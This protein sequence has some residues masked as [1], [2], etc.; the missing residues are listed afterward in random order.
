MTEHDIGIV[1]LGYVGLTLA[2][3]LADVGYSVIGVE[4]RSHLV[5]LTNRGLPH[6]SEAGLG[7]AL[8]RVTSAGKLVAAK[9]FGPD[10]TCGTYIIT[11]GTPLSET[12]DVRLDMIEAA[13]QQVAGNMPDD[14]LVILRS[15]V[16]VETTRKVVAPILARTGK[17]FHIAMCP[18]RTL[19]GRALQELRE[20][21]Q[22]IGADDPIA[23]DRAAAVFQRITSTIVKVSTPE[24]A[25]IVKLVDNT[26][27]DVQFAFANEVA[28]LCEAFRVNAHEV[29]SSGKL[30]YSRT[31]VA[32]PGLV[33][34]PC[35]E[36]DPHI[37]IQSAQAQGMTLEIT[38][39]ARLV[40]E[41]Q[42]IETVGFVKKEV[43]RRGLSH[44]LR[45]RVVGM[46]FKG[47]PA[48]DDLRGSMSVKVLAALKDA[49]PDAEFGVF[50]PV[51]KPE[52][53]QEAFPAEEVF[54]TL[55]EAIQ[56][57]SVLVIANNHP[58]LGTFSPRTI[59]EIIAD[60]GFVFDFW[61]HFSHLPTSELGDSYFAVGNT[62]TAG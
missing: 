52:L 30:G 1:G 2:T 19:E 41:R 8:R 11:V 43:A 9:E 50:D 49:H 13:T 28:R 40:N 10:I 31:N 3:V 45:I 44:P 39:A 58:D 38:S 17:R 5:D 54:S 18:E 59:G 29:I 61:N 16:K 62:E 42:P 24:T 6:F 48:T 25:E 20:L 34:G 33:G 27:R 55:D 37:L 51:I 53:L 26:F 60:G 57:A 14:A 32:L 36:K 56:G 35:L 22:I 15:T 4:K 7:D 12:G 46:A 23:S 21:P 47:V